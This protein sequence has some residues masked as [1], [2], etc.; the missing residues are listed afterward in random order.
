M[1][2]SGCLPVARI[3]ECLAP[4]ERTRGGGSH[5]ELDRTTWTAGSSAGQVATRRG[6]MALTPLEMQAP[7]VTELPDPEKEKEIA[8]RSPFQIAMAAL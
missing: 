1:S 6:D 2:G 7:D 3:T 5:G 8:G 4:A